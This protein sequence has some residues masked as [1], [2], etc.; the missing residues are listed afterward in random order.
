[1]ALN[2]HIREVVTFLLTFYH[3]NECHNSCDIKNFL[4]MVHYIFLLY[5][6]QPYN[7]ILVQLNYYTPKVFFWEG[8]G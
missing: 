4:I 5:N 3:I 8:F 6:C 7:N 1:M 2:I